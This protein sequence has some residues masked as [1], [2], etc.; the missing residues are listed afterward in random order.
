MVKI[1]TEM[2]LR[3]NTRKRIINQKKILTILGK[4]MNKVTKF[5]HLRNKITGVLGLTKEIKKNMITEKKIQKAHILLLIKFNTKKNAK[6][7]KLK[8]LE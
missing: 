6:K 8:K 7:S 5:F 1:I 3:V 2:S 4:K